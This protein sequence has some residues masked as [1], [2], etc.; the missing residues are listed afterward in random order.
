VSDLYCKRVPA[1]K[2]VMDIFFEEEDQPLT[3][4]DV[5]HW[6]TSRGVEVLREEECSR[7]L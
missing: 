1:P 2:E 3:L 6:Y 7:L 4:E 5:R